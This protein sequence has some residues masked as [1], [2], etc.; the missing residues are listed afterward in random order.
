MTIIEGSPVRLLLE[1]W[2]GLLNSITY[3]ASI[4]QQDAVAIFEDG[5]NSLLGTNIDILLNISIFELLVGTNLAVALIGGVI[6]F[7]VNIVKT[8]IQW[9]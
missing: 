4:L 2:Y 6:A 8:I 1:L 5:I 9:W 7:Y 3:F